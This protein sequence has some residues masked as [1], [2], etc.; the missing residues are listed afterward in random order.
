LS[1]AGWP[2]GLF[3]KTLYVPGFA[4]IQTNNFSFP[5]GDYF[6]ME[7]DELRAIHVVWGEGQNYKTPGSIGYAR[8]Q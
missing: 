1:D 7:R 2:I 5:F 6:E 4:Y 3:L 8:G